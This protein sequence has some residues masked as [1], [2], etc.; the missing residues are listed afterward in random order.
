MSLENRAG[1]KEVFYFEN[2]LS[3]IKQDIT[4]E[5]KQTTKTWRLNTMLLNNQ[6]IP[7]EI[8]KRKSKNF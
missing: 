3:F 4:K 2:P 6:W 1:R 5:K 8:P 7:E